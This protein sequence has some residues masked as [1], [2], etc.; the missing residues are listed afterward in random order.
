MAA[1][2]RDYQAAQLRAGRQDVIAPRGFDPDTEAWARVNYGQWI[3]D[4]PFCNSAILADSDDLRF[5]CVECS[6]AEN[7][8]RWV[9]VIW[10]ENA[11]AI[12]HEL[13]QRRNEANRNWYPEESIVRLQAENLLERDV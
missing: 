10:P 11:A 7:G 12:E 6:S 8:H 4:C 5:F 13:M 3:I 9:D 2:V 1:F